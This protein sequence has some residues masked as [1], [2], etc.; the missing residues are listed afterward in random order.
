MFRDELP[1]C[2]VLVLSHEVLGHS[3]I[4]PIPSIPSGCFIESV[5][6]HPDYRGKGLGKFIMACTEDYVRS[7]ITELGESLYPAWAAP[8]P[9]SKV[10]PAIR[11]M[12]VEAYRPST[13]LQ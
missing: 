3:K 11:R 5:V 2:L 8:L 12:S 10:F 9:F 1:T 7:N 6:I 4:S 13:C